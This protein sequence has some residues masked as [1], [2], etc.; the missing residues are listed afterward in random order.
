MAWEESVV[1]FMRPPW[2]RVLGDGSGYTARTVIATN[3]RCCDFIPATKLVLD[4]AFGDVADGLFGIAERRAA[5]AAPYT[6]D[7]DTIDLH[8]GVAD[9]R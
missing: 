4:R 5:S 2:R 7:S 1:Q 8:L 3:D 9:A 6:D